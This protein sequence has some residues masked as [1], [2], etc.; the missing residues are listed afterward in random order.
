MEKVTRQHPRDDIAFRV[1]YVDSCGRGGMGLATNVSYTGMY[2]A[3][4]PR[5]RVGD[6]LH[7]VL[8]LPTGEPCKL[9][10]RVVRTDLTGAGLCFTQKMQA[11]LAGCH[12]MN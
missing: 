3:Y 5:L 4:I 12:E 2:L 11:L 1:D 8:V 9:K 7:M 6:L 10:A